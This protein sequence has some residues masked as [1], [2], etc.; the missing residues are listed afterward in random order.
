MSMGDFIFL[1]SEVVGSIH[2]SD[3]YFWF[4]FLSD[5]K[6]QF[7]PDAMNP[8]KQDHRFLHDLIAK[9][10]QKRRCWR[11]LAFAKKSLRRYIGASSHLNAVLVSSFRTVACACRCFQ[12]THVPNIQ[13][14]M[15]G[16]NNQS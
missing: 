2:A 8:Y 15:Y 9:D 11:G 13:P 4:S 16:I 3:S 12:L 5:P 7:S 1:H 10:P 6:F 14:Q